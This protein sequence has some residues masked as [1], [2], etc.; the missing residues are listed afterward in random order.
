MGQ[1]KIKEEAHPRWR[2]A[3]NYAYTKRLTRDDWAWE[4]L[5]RDRAH[6]QLR[7]NG[8][9]QDHNREDLPAGSP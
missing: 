6:A 3:S 4:F 8:R 5:R 9:C 2:D 7:T 1:E